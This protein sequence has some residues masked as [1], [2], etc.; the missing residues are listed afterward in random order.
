LGRRRAGSA[1]TQLQSA[2][3]VVVRKHPAQRRQLPGGFASRPKKADFLLDKEALIGATKKCHQTL[4][5]GGK[6]SSLAALRI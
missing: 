5:A 1:D 4:W 2:K 3:K 6:L